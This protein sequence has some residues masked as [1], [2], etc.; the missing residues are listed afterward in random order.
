MTDRLDAAALGL[1]R[2]SFESLKR[3]FQGVADRGEPREAWLMRL[4]NRPDLT[5]KAN[6]ALMNGF[7]DRRLGAFSLGGERWASLPEPLQSVADDAAR[8]VK[9]LP[10]NIAKQLPPECWCSTRNNWP[11]WV[12]VVFGLAWSPVPN[13]LPHA[14]RLVPLNDR[15]TILLESVPNMKE[16]PLHLTD[17]QIAAVR[18][19]GW[20]S[21]L[22]DFAAASVQ[23]IDILQNW[24]GDVPKEVPAAPAGEVKPVDDGGL[25]KYQD[26]LT[27]LGKRILKALWN[28]Q[29]AV[30][31]D[32]L[33]EEAW[34]GDTVSD[35]G[36]ERRLQDIESRWAGANL[37]DID[38]EIS[39]ATTSV[40]L[41]KP[42]PKTGDKK[43]DN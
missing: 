37:V 13:S 5:L 27:P 10:E 31:F 4:A 28:H 21:T 29:F 26:P 20:Y 7:D 42:P 39:L 41:V 33:R 3:R 25:A 22:D 32:T 9:R 34:E 11:L 8:L 15:E 23:A 35:S 19:K 18:E 36:I 2:S 14:V 17:E 40:K 16:W 1:L 30:Q 38:L 24:L 12:A 6:F 43:G